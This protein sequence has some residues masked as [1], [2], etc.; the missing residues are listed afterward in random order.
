MRSSVATSLGHNRIL[1]YFKF[2]YYTLPSF[3]QYILIF[4]IT[5]ISQYLKLYNIVT[6]LIF[7]M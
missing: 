3:L 7:S 6:H 1:D 4:V 2:P 5:E